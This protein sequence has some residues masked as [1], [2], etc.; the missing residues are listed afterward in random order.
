VR[1][2][3]PDTLFCDTRDGILRLQ[4]T[5]EWDERSQQELSDRIR[6]QLV[7]GVRCFLVDM[8]HT[9]HIRYQVLADLKR[10]YGDVRRAGG[11]LVLAAPS[12]YLLE[13]L[14]AGDVPRTIPVYPSE[15]SAAMGISHAS[16]ASFVVPQEGERRGSGL[17]V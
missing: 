4:P 14:A 7:V 15:A 6:G 11:E 3:M 1:E 9:I 13:I 16:A 8:T 5:D 10:L 17:G 2:T 12:S